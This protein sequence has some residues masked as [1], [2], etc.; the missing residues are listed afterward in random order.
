MKND[1]LRAVVEA[2]PFAWTEEG[3][4]KTGLRIIFLKFITVISLLYFFVMNK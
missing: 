3:T 1:E 4:M 2:D